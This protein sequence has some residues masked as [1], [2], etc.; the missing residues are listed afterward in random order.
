ME[1]PAG[2]LCQAPLAHRAHELARETVQQDGHGRRQLRDQVTAAQE[3]LVP[4]APLDQD[5]DLEGRHLQPAVGQIGSGRPRHPLRVIFCR[6]E[7]GRHVPLSAAELGHIVIVDHHA[8]E[9]PSAGSHRRRGIGHAH[10]RLDLADQC[11]S[12]DIDAH[13]GDRVLQPVHPREDRRHAA[14]DP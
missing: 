8:L 6:C 9:P 3:D 5:R 13:A 1:P 12:V 10:R 2:A 11:L 14:G 4:P 7:A